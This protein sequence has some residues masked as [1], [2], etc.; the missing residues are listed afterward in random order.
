MTPTQL[1]TEITKIYEAFYPGDTQ[2]FDYLNRVLAGM[3]EPQLKKLY[4]DLK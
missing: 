1:K 4:E 2:F 3:S